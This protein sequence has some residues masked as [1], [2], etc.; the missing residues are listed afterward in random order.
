[1]SDAT[2]A[3]ETRSVR[4]WAPDLARFD[5]FQADKSVVNLTFAYSMAASTT[6]VHYDT[7]VE[8]SGTVVESN[9]PVCLKTK[10]FLTDVR[11]VDPLLK[12]IP[13]EVTVERGNLSLRCEELAIFATG[14]TTEQ[15]MD[16]FSTLFQEQYEHYTSLP[17]DKLSERAAAIRDNFL[18]VL[19]NKK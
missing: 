5:L 15:V 12:P 2:G 19:P 8:Q 1:M 14:K 3:I 16:E 10:V 6:V 17:K 18:T 4:A 13:V 7:V 11:G 9:E